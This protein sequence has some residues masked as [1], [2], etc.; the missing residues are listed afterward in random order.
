VTTREC[1]KEMTHGPCGGVAFDGSCEVGDRSCAFAGGAVV[2][3]SGPAA[4]VAVVDPLRELAARRS[5]VVADLPVA[6]SR[7]DD[8]RRAVA[9]LAG[10]IDAALFGD[11]GI[12]RVQLPP[13]YRAALVAAEGVRP[14]AGVNC[15]DRNRVALEGE[16]AALADVGAAVHCITG[17]HT[18]LGHRPDAKAVFDLDSTELVSLASRAGLFASVAEN[19]VAPPTALRPAR[20]VEKVRAGASACFVNHAGHRDVVQAF[21]EEARLLGAAGTLFVVCVPV[22]FSLASLA[23]IRTFTALA[24]PAALLASIESAADPFVEG[25]RQALAFA[26]AVLDVP[27]VSGVD[28]SLAPAPGEADRAL[29]AIR[30]IAKELM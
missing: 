3:W 27:G 12:A 20:L 9:S 11:M 15:R 28:L 8:V 29:E 18:D 17:D 16:L 23:G 5:L 21:V 14:W 22:V 6:S 25:V 19:P 13:S 1:P 26:A 2:N 10:R 24:L 7:A 4:S 30:T